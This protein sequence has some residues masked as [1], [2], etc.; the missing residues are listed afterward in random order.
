MANITVTINPALSAAKK[1][2]A[3]DALKWKFKHQD[4]IPDENGDLIDNPQTINDRLDLYVE[5]Q[6]RDIISEYNDY[7]ALQAKST[8][9]L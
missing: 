1:K 5:N 6:V 3:S 7:L 4:Q 8:D 2:L 9:N